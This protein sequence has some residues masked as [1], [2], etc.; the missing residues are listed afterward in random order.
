MALVALNTNASMSAS[1]G[2]FVPSITGLVAGEAIYAGAACYIKGADGKVY[3]ALGTAANEAARLAGFAPA[4]AGIGEPVSLYGIGSRWYYSTALTPGVA[5][6]LATTAGRLD[7]A[8]TTGD[9]TGVAAAITAT[10][11]RITR[12]V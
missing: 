11:I 5:L 10:D 7:T 6:F 12:A 9:A 4:A 1:V 8:A 3:L 2:M